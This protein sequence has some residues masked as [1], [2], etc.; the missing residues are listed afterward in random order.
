[1][2]QGVSPEAP[3]S[4]RRNLSMLKAHLPKVNEIGPGQ[5][6][7]SAVSNSFPQPRAVLRTAKIIQG[8][9]SSAMVA[10]VDIS[11]KDPIQ[12][13]GEMVAVLKPDGIEVR[14]LMRDDGVYMLH[15]WQPG[16]STVKLRPQGEWSLAGQVLSIG[17][18]ATVEADGATAE[19]RMALEY[20]GIYGRVAKKLGVTIY[21]IRS[22]VNGSTKSKRVC[23]ALDREVSRIK[24]ESTVTAASVA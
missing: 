11:R 1:M 9:A 23:V 5:R 8:T 17:K 20:Y 18:A 19:Q 16:Q 4:G 24:G 10:Q 7:T 6:Q 13:V 3:D 15:P 14:W 22:V 12:L 2:Q 21:H